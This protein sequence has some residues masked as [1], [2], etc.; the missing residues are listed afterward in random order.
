[1]I[2]SKLKAKNANSGQ[3]FRPDWVSS[4]E[5]MPHRIEQLAC[6]AAVVNGRAFEFEPS[7]IAITSEHFIDN[8]LHAS[9]SILCGIHSADETQSGRNSCPEF[10]FLAFS[11]SR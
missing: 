4:A 5:C 10:A 8:C 6:H 11:L 2:E 7:Q 1:M 3:L 9:C